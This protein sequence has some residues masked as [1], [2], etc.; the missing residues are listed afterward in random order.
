MISTQRGE[1]ILVFKWQW[2]QLLLDGNKTLEIRSLALRKGRYLLGCKGEIFGWAEIGHPMHIE[3]IAQWEALRHRHLVPLEVLPYKK[4]YG[5]PILRV[6][7]MRK[8]I[9]FVHPRGAVGI[10]RMS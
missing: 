8:P 5:L 3:N 10:V 1:R 9:P 7:R 2:L 6:R 4:T